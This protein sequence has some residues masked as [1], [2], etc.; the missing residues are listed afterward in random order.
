MS[1]G[2]ST[3]NAERIEGGSDG[4]I[5]GNVGDRLKVTSDAVIVV[6][7]NT[8]ATI[9][10]RN[11]IT[12]ATKTESDLSGVTYTVPS[13]KNFVLTTVNANYDTQ[14]PLYIRLKKQTGGAGSFVTEIR[15]TVKQHGQDASSTSMTFPYGIYLATAGDVLKITYESALAK[16]TLW[17]AFTGVEY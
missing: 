15:L 8:F 13:G 2:G 4:S 7:A 9:F 14:S 11:E 3:D 16:G 6:S 10:K 5:I 12:V 17:A 1:G